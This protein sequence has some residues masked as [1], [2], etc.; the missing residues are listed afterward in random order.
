MQALCCWWAVSFYSRQPPLKL[1][2]S[3]SW[4]STT[5]GRGQIAPHPSWQDSLGINV[6][7]AWSL[8]CREL[9]LLLQAAV[10]HCSICWPPSAPLPN[11]LVVLQ[12]GAAQHFNLINFSTRACICRQHQFPARMPLRRGCLS[13]NQNAKNLNIL[14]HLVHIRVLPS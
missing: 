14:L 4:P 12:T 3:L 1:N 10:H 7:V 8:L 6:R 5:L 9:F 11:L 2:D 13:L